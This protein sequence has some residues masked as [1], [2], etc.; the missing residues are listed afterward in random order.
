MNILRGRL[1]IVV[2]LILAG[3]LAAG[4]EMVFQTSRRRG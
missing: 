4:Q 1:A 2:V 3:V